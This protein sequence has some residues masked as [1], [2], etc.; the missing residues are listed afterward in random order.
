VKQQVLEQ[1]R[2]F[3]TDLQTL[4]R[5]ISALPGDRVSRRAQREAA[6]SIATRWVEDLRSPLEHRFKLTPEV[7]QSASESMKRLHV[8]SRPNN[9]KTS[10]LEVIDSVL[11]A[12]DDRFI[13]P[14]QQTGGQ[15]ESVLDL[16]KLVPGLADPAES[17]YLKEAINCATNGF[18]RASVV[19]GWCAA[20]DRI[21]KKLVQVGLQAFNAASMRLKAQ[22]S[23]KFKNWN[24]QFSVTTVSE[25]QTIFDRDLIVALEGM[26]LLDGNQAERMQTCFQYRNH[27]AHPGEA[28]IEDPHLVAFFAD[29]NSVILQNPKFAL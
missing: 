3:K 4:K 19:M 12:F 23:G 24:K 16:A 7:I 9:L 26:G 13:L 20:I 5:Q 6:D 28:P 8:L 29:V 25:L 14:I 1:L 27:S 11:R 2:Q 22:T 15:I 17:D 18:R 10:Y 21:Q